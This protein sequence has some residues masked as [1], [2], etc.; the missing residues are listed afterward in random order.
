MTL[1]LL[2]TESKFRT[3]S[4]WN[5]EERQCWHSN[6]PV[7]NLSILCPWNFLATNCYICWIDT[8]TSGLRSFFTIY[9]F[10]SACWTSWSCS[11]GPSCVDVKERVLS[12]TE[13]NQ[14]LIELIFNSFFLAPAPLLPLYNSLLTDHC[15]EWWRER[16]VTVTLP[17][18]IKTS[19]TLHK[20]HL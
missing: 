2:L 20:M 12:K 15:R 9:T 8:E 17:I 6:D 3:W 7:V 1:I 11:R 4:S 5:L 16:M 18:P 13:S 19:H 14:K 10:L